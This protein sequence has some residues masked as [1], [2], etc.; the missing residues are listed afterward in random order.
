MTASGLYTTISGY[1]VQL[2]TNLSI[3]TIEARRWTCQLLA[4]CRK[5][6]LS[7]WAHVTEEHCSAVTFG[8]VWSK[9]KTMAKELKGN[10]HSDHFTV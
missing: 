10:V 5:L 2:T 6:V 7:S 8:R 3:N 9:V 1:I 4:I